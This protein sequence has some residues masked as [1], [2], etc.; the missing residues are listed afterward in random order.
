MME[1]Q[2]RGR[3]ERGWL[4]PAV[5]RRGGGAS[6]SSS[7]A[8][9]VRMRMHVTDRRGGRVRRAAVLSNACAQ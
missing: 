4:R 2:N 5:R 9:R 7:R 6:A 1:T 8:P 3:W